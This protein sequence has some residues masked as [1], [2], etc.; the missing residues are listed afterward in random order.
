MFG[1]EK[2]RRI[3]RLE[4][5]KK[6]SRRVNVYLDDVFAFGL[7]KDVVLEHGLH[8][9]DELSNTLIEKVLGT[10]ERTRAKQKALALLSYRARSVEELRG[11]LVEKG[12][13]ED[14]IESTMEDLR[15]VGLLDDVKFAASFVHTQMTDKP[16]SKR[17]LTFELRKKGIEET[18]IEKAVEEEYGSEAEVDVARRLA[19]RRIERFSGEP[20]KLKK[21]LVDF[22]G[23]RGFGWDVISTVLQEVEWEEST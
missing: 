10:E 3:T 16:M 13:S 2:T 5:Q 8:E 6:R 19:M 1:S 18:V 12:F 15:R 4:P 22:L 20:K 7:E 9:G 14:S 17:M 21:R 23:R 11:K